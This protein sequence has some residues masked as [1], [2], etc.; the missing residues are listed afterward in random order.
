MSEIGGVFYFRL[1]DQEVPSLVQIATKHL[2]NYFINLVKHV[3][4]IFS[5]LTLIHLI[6]AIQF[7]FKNAFII[8]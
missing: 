5:D 2:G 6:F 1:R 8:M 4:S 3:L 7:Q